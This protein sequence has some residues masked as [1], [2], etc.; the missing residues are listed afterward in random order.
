[1]AMVTVVMNIAAPAISQVR[2]NESQT[3]QPTRTTKPN[4]L[5]NDR[6]EKIEIDE[7][8]LE[9]ETETARAIVKPGGGR[10]A[11]FL[12]CRFGPQGGSRDKC[13]AQANE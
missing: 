9:R 7:V 6:E 13:A 5:V 4:N 1:M 2:V 3:R 12:W 10:I 8:L 11:R